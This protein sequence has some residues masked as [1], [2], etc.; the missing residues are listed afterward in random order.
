MKARLI[1]GIFILSVLI[2]VC[3]DSHGC[4]PP[5]TTPPIP[6]P[7][8]W[9]VVP[10]ATS[11]TSIS[12]KA[13][14]ATDASGVEY[15][16][17]CTTSGG[18]DS[19]WQDGTTYTDTGLQPNTQYCYRVRAR[20]KS[21]NHNLTNW[22]TTTPCAT[23][24]EATPPSPDPMTW[25]TVPYATGS[26]SIAMVATTA[27]D[28]SGVEYFFDCTTTGGHDSVWQ[29]NTSYTDTGLS[30]STQYCYKVQA[31]DKS[32]NQNAT[33]WSTTQCA[34]TQTGGDTTPPT[35]NPAT[36]ASVPT[37]VSDTA[38]TMTA[39]TGTDVSGPV[40][41]SFDETSGNPGGT[42][43]G[44][45]TNPVY[46]DS[47]LQPGTQYTYT[48]QMRD[49]LLNTGTASG[50]LSAITHP[51]QASNPTPANGVTDV[52]LTQD[53]SWDPVSGATSYDV[54]FGTVS[55]GTFQGNQ[56]GTTF[57]TGTMSTNTTY[58]WRIDAKNAG[59]TTT[60]DVWSFTTQTPPSPDP[61]T[62]ATEP[63]ATGE[64][65]ISMTA[66]TATDVSGV[67]YYF[68]CAAG[69]CHD[70]GWQD[71][72]TYQDTGLSAGTGYSYQ[73]KARDKSPNQNETNWSLVKSA[74]TFPG[75][76]SNLSPDV[77]A[78]DVSVDVDLRWIPGQGATSHDVYFGTDSSAV[79]NANT[80]S[81]EWKGNQQTNIY[82][83]PTPLA[84][85]TTYFWRIDEKNTS[86]TTTGYV[87]SFTTIVAPPGQAT[88][89]NPTNGS[90]NVDV[91]VE[92]SWTAGSGATSHNI[93][94]GES[95]TLSAGDLKGNQI[96]TTFDP[97]ILA[98]DTPYY[99]RIDEKNAGGTTVGETWSFRTE[100]LDPPTPNPMNWVTEPHPA[101]TTTISMMATTASD[102]RGVEYYFE[103]IAGNGHDSGWVNSATFVDSGLSPGKQYIYR[104]KARD[105]SSNSNET[106]WSVS[107]ATTI[108]GKVRN[109]NK[110]TWHY[111]IQ[112]AID[113]ATS[114]NTLVVLEG[115]YSE[116]IAVS[117]K[118]VILTSTNPEFRNVVNNTI[119]YG[120]GTT[121]VVKFISAGGSK[122][123]G[124]TVKNSGTGASASDSSG[125]YCEGTANLD[126][127]DCNV[128][129]NKYGIWCDATSTTPG[130]K[131][132]IVRINTSTGIEAGTSNPTI[133]N[134]LVHNNGGD[135]ISV[136]G[137]AT[138][139]N[140]TV[141]YNNKGFNCTAAQI[142]NCIDWGNT[143]NSTW[144]SST[145][146]YSCVQDNKSGEGNFN[147]D[148]RFVDSV[149][150]NYHLQATI[151]P[152]VNSGSTSP[153]HRVQADI[154]GQPR[155]IGYKVDIGA[156]EA[157]VSPTVWYVNG[158]VTASGAGTSW[159][160]AFK[161]LQDALDNGSLEAGH[162]I[163][164]AQGTYKPDEATSGHTNNDRN[165][166]FRL[167]VDVA[168]YG[169]FVGGENSLAERDWTYNKTILSGDI[170]DDDIDLPDS[171]NSYHVITSG[172]GAV[173][174][175]FVITKGYANNAGDFG[176]GGMLNDGV[177][178]VLRNCILYANHAADGL[179]GG[180][181]YNRNSSAAIMNCIFNGNKTGVDGGGIYNDSSHITLINCTITDNFAGDDAGGIYNVSSNPTVTNC[182]LWNNEDNGGTGLTAQID[183]GTPV[184]SYSC[185][186]DWVGGTGNIGTP[187]QFVNPG[188]WDA[189]TVPDSIIVQATVRDLKGQDETG[190]HPDFEVNPYAAETGIVGPYGAALDI[191]GKPDYALGSSGS[192][193][194]DPRVDTTHG[195]T[196][197]YDWYH[198][199]TNNMSTPIWLELTHQGNGV[200][201][202]RD[203]RFFPIDGHLFATYHTGDGG[204]HNFH[205]TLELH[206]IFT[207][208]GTSEYFRLY[209]S[210]DDMF[211]YID[212]KLVLDIGGV[213]SP[214][215]RYLRI[216]D[217]DGYGGDVYLYMEVDG[218]GDPIAPHYAYVDLNLQPNETYTF[219]LFYAERHTVQSHLEFSTTI[220]LKINFT[221]GDYHLQAGS[222]CIDAGD[223][224][225]VPVGV[226]TDLE[227]A[228][229]FLDDPD[230]DDTGNEGAQG[231]P[232]VDMGAYEYQAEYEELTV[233]AGE[234]KVVTLPANTEKLDEAEILVNGGVP[235]PHISWEWS[236]KSVPFGCDIDFDHY[237][238]NPQLTLTV[239]P[240]V[241]ELAEYVEYRLELSAYE[242]LYD[243]SRVLLKSDEVKI[244]VKPGSDSQ[245]SPQVRAIA[246][247]AA[248]VG[249][250]NIAEITLPDNTLVI[251]GVIR[252]DGAPSGQLM[253]RWT[254]IV[255]GGSGASGTVNFPPGEQFVDFRQQIG[256]YLDFSGEFYANTTATFSAAGEYVIKL[257]ASDGAPDS[258][259][260]ALID[261]TVNPD[262]SQNLPPEV[263]AGPN[264]K[265]NMS[266]ENY[267]NLT[268][269]SAKDDHGLVEGQVTWST[270]SG[271][272]NATFG[273]A[274]P[275][276]VNT[277]TT[278]T[279][280]KAG[281]YVLKLA[282]N[283]GSNPEVG[284]RMKVEVEQ[285]FD[286]FAGPDRTVTIPTSPS[287]GDLYIR[288]AS[289][290]GGPDDMT[291]MWTWVKLDG[292]PNFEV[293][294]DDTSI[295]KPTVTFYE[296]GTYELTLSAYDN[297]EL[298]GQ[299]NAVITVTTDLQSVEKKL[300]VVTNHN[301]CE[302]S[303]FRTVDDGLMLQGTEDTMYFGSGPIGL[304]V[305]PKYGRVFVGYHGNTVVGII[306]AETMKPEATLNTDFA[307]DGIKWDQINERLYCL[308]KY[309][310]EI[311]VFQ[312]YSENN[313]FIHLGNMMLSDFQG[314]GC[315]IALNR[316]DGLLYVTNGTTM[317][318]SYALNEMANPWPQKSSQNISVSRK[319]VGIDFRSNSGKRYIYTGGGY[320][321]PYHEY[322]VRTEVGGAGSNEIH[323]GQY[324]SV[325]GVSVDNDTGFVYVTTWNETTATAEIR[326]Y[327]GELTKLLYSNSSYTNG[328]ATGIC[329]LNA[330][331]QKSPDFYLAVD[332]QL[333]VC[334]EPPD[335]ITYDI[336]YKAE[337]H[338][339]T[340]VEVI[341]YLPVELDFDSATDGG[342]YDSAS[343]TVTWTLPDF[344][345]SE[346]SH[347]YL[348][349]NVNDRAKP[350]GRILNFCK[351][352]SD[353]Y[354]TPRTEITEVCCWPLNQQIIYV[355]PRAVDGKNNGTS[356]DDAYTHL[357][358]ALRQAKSLG[359]AS[360]NAIWVT[361]GLMVGAFELADGVAVYGGFA[362]FES[363]LNERDLANPE[364]ATALNGGGFYPYVV[365]GA[366][367]AIL[368]GFTVCGGQEAGI[369]G[370]DVSMTIANCLIEYNHEGIHLGCASA[371]SY[372]SP[373]LIENN[374]IRENSSSGIFCST[375]TIKNN[376]IC[377]NH[378]SGV[379]IYSWNAGTS[380]AV[381]RNN[382]I[383]YNDS[384][385]IFKEGYGPSAIISN[386]I[387]WG[388]SGSQLQNC[389]A[390]YS[391]I[392][393]DPGSGT[394]IGGPPSF[395]NVCD[396]IDTVHRGYIGTDG[397][398]GQIDA[399]K[400]W[401]YQINDVIEIEND[402][403]PRN[404]TDVLHDTYWDK[405]TFE[406]SFI[407]YKQDYYDTPIYN[408]GANDNVYEDYHIQ[409]NSPCID[410]GEPGDY[411]GESDIDGDN[412]VIEI[413]GKGDGDRDVDI[414]ADEFT[415]LPSITV[416]AGDYGPIV[417]PQTG[418]YTLTL[419]DAWVTPEWRINTWGWSV[420]PGAG[421]TL[422]LNDWFD[423]STIQFSSPGH[424]Y[425]TLTIN[426]GPS[427]VPSTTEVWV[428]PHADNNPPYVYPGNTQAVVLSGDTATATMRGIVRD[429][430]LPNGTL[431]KQWLPVAGVT[432]TDNSNPGTVATF[433]RDDIYE[434]T[435]R[436]DDSE[437]V[438]SKTVR[439]V[440]LKE[441][442]PPVISA[443]PEGGYTRNVSE[444]LY[445]E[446][447][448]IAADPQ[449]EIK[450][451]YW[452]VTALPPE[453]W[454]ASLLAW[455]PENAKALHP[456]VAFPLHGDYELQLNVEFQ[457]GVVTDTVTD[458]VTVEVIDETITDTTDPALT[459]NTTP[460]P[461]PANYDGSIVINASATDSDSGVDYISLKVDSQVLDSV[462]G[463]PSY[464]TTLPLDYTLPTYSISNGAHTL[465]AKAVDRVGKYNTQQINFSSN[466]PIYNF[467]VTPEIATPGDCTVTISASFRDHGASDTWTLSIPEAS[468]TNSG[469]GPTMS[470]QV[471]VCEWDDGTYTVHLEDKNH[472]SEEITFKVMMNSG[473]GLTAEIKNLEPI[474]GPLGSEK[475]P[476]ITNGF[477][478]LKGIADHE[479]FASDVSYKIEVFD[480]QAEIL[481]KN[482]TPGA[483]ADGFCHGTVGDA[484]TNIEGDFGQLDLSGLPNKT[485]QLLLTV[486]CNGVEAYDSVK[487]ALDCP[488]KIGNVKF[489]QEDL[490]VPIGGIP[491]RVVRTYDSLN[492]LFDSEFGYG[493][494][495]SIAN[496]DIELN[497]MRQPM[498]NWT[499]RVGGN[500]DRDVTLTL[501]NGTRATFVCELQGDGPYNVVYKAPPGVTATLEPE[502]S[503]TLVYGGTCIG[504]YWLFDGIDPSIPTTCEV[505]VD[506]SLHDF[507]GF[508]LTTED[509]TKYHISRKPY[510]TQTIDDPFFDLGELYFY[511]AYGKP[512]LSSIETPNGEKIEFVVAGTEN[513]TVTGVTHYQPAGAGG[514]TPTKAIKIQYYN[515]GINNG[516]IEK[517]YPPSELVDG[518]G[519][520]I[521]GA[522]PSLKYEYLNGN[523][524]EVHKL[525]DRDTEQYEVI[526]YS[527]RDE[528]QGIYER[529]HYVTDIK[530]PRGISPI[531]Y[532]YNDDGQ[533]IGIFDAKNEYITIN[534]ED[535]RFPT[536]NVEV[537]LD[538]LGNETIYF[539]NARGNVVTIQNNLGQQTTYT[540][541]T[542][543]NID[544]PASITTPTPTGSAVTTYQ[545]TNY[546]NGTVE[547]EIITDPVYNVTANVYDT[548][549]NVTETSQWRFTGTNPS[550]F[551]ADYAEVSRTTSVYYYN[552][553]GTLNLLDQGTLTNLLA[554]TASVDPSTGNAIERTDYE[555]D[556][557]MRLW[558]VIKREIPALLSQTDDVSD[559]ITSYWYDAASN[560]PDRPYSVSEPYY[561]SQIGPG[562]PTYVNYS[563]YNANGNQD[564]SWTEWDDPTNG[565]GIDKYVFTV[566]T[567]DSQ[568]R[569]I[570]TSRIVDDDS[571]PF[572]PVGDT[573]LSE[574]V[575]TSTQYNSIG[576]VDLIL[577]EHS[578]LTK[579]GYDE[580]GNIVETLLYRNS[581]DYLA[582]TPDGR[583][584]KYVW[585]GSGYVETIFNS[586]S[587]FVSDSG[588][589]LLTVSQT[590]YDIDGRAVISVGPYD[591]SDTA[592]PPVGTET[593][594]DTLG[595]VIGT[596]RWA[597]VAIQTQNV[598]N[599]QGQVVGKSA[600]GWTTNGAAP[601]AGNELSYTKTIYDVASRVQMSIT[602]NEQG[603]EQP[604]GYKYDK[605]GKQVAVADATDYGLVAGTDYEANGRWYVIKNTVLTSLLAIDIETLA[606]VSKT[607]YKGNQRWKVTDDRNNITEFIYDALGRVIT[608]KY[609]QTVV[610]EGGVTPI[611]TYT[612]VGYDSLGGKEWQSE[613]TD[614]DEIASLTDE[615]GLRWFEYDAAG[616]LTA[617]ILAKV[618]VNPLPLVEDWKRPRCEYVYD[619]FGNLVEQWDKITE[620][621]AEPPAIDPTNK[622]QTAFTYD[623]LN[624]QTSRTLPN[625][626]TE[627]TAYDDFGRV[628][629][630]IDFKE[631]AT[632]YFYNGR[633]QLRYKRYYEADG[634]V[635][636]G[637]TNYPDTWVQQVEYT[638]D[639]L[640]R[641]TQII[642]SGGTTEY[643]YDT[644]G[645]MIVVKSPEGYV[646]YIYSDV[647]GRKTQTRSYAVTANLNSDV[648]AASN[649][650]VT[651]VEYTYE[652]L[653]R[654]YEAKTVKRNSNT[655]S[656]AE[657]TTYNYDY[658]GNRSSTTTAN[659]VNGVTATY[660]NDNCNRLTNLSN[661]HNINGA[662]SSFAYGLYAN[663]MRH[664][665]T[666]EI[667]TS[668][669]PTSETHNITY[670]YDNLNRLTDEDAY[671]TTPGDTYN[672]DYTYDLVG[673]RFSR[674]VIANSQ[675][676]QTNY[677]YD[678]TDASVD[679]LSR[680]EHAGPVACVPIGDERYYA[681]ADGG[682][683]T[684]KTSAGVSIGKLKAFMLGLPNEAARYMLALVLVLVPVSFFA[685]MF[686]RLIRHRGRRVQRAKYLLRQ[687]LIVLLAYLMLIQPGW[688]ESVAEASSQYSQ[689]TTGDWATYKYINYTYD[690][691][692]SCIT[693]TTKNDSSTVV[694]AVQYDYN[695]RNKL[696]KV[697]TDPISGS[698]VSVV[699][700]TYND[701][702]IRVKAYS[703]DRL[704]VGETK[705]N[706]KTT[707]FLVDAYNHTGYAQ[708]LE[709]SDGTTRTTYTVGDDVITQCTGATPKHLIYDGHGSTR[710]LTDVSGALVADQVFNYDGY[711]VRIG[712]TGTSQTNLQYAGEYYDTA[713]K[714]YNL[715]ARYYNPLN[716]RFNQMD[717]FAGSPQDPQSLHKYLYC[718]AN[719]VNGIDPNGQEFSFTG[720]LVSIAIGAVIGAI[721]SFAI[722][723]RSYKAGGINV[724][725]FIIQI[726]LGALIGALT[727]AAGYL[728]SIFIGSW[729]RTLAISH[730]LR[731]ILT[732]ALSAAASAFFGQVIT[733][734]KY[735]MIDK[736]P[737]VFRDSL[738]RAILATCIGFV[739]GGVLVGLSL[740]MG[741]ISD[742]KMAPIL[743][744]P[745]LDPHIEYLPS[746]WLPEPAAVGAL[747]EFKVTTLGII[748]GVA[749]DS[750]ANEIDKHL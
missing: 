260:E 388:N 712:Y 337:G 57:D 414:G 291:L 540:Y 749:S 692:G 283:D 444:V 83:P 318:Y 625:N 298:L 364:Y 59:G 126:I 743:K 433:E 430:G 197:F 127:R 345:G 64:T 405:I 662:L 438:T 91:E 489:S 303:Y 461:I 630:N 566:N 447:A 703:Y 360:V 709:E 670:S 192:N 7:M 408:W 133:L 98:S 747:A 79:S 371:C 617:T 582:I 295:E 623:W 246:E 25:A 313:E 328:T 288:E 536:D 128:E 290:T 336:H 119:I 278:A 311:A 201:E 558:H 65:S 150:Y 640:G 395:A 720:L 600:I 527:Y 210:D 650:D 649:N 293:Y 346:N 6:N 612:H 102:L 480:N 125:I 94:F 693:K 546:A 22:S 683:L 584:A 356:W 248:Q 504:Y 165:E 33:G 309:G 618:D 325:L 479:I 305:D 229:R 220:E 676:L 599:S 135:G 736:K 386:C 543:A 684:Y 508:V 315:D 215:S 89:P 526:K 202:F 695:L 61:M 510:G 365:T 745:V 331:P 475:I 653:G 425:V 567:L 21:P 232:V 319:A 107:A 482:V 578:N 253:A 602:L 636:G 569:A 717:S 271:P 714:Q 154:D 446:D 45:T 731:Y 380:A 589:S 173:V 37:A 132:N 511:E 58:Y 196:Y 373:P 737:F 273:D 211:L 255:L 103:C 174:D 667:K 314:P 12:M 426:P 157:D 463:A 554:W 655:V 38:I 321:N 249:Q 43:S 342:V 379:Y 76:A 152:C 418:T 610:Q 423:E 557:K 383:A 621:L 495:Y 571:N 579:Y 144:G 633:G 551:P 700:Y 680:E 531:R 698:T 116:N 442:S 729:L 200:Y 622:R 719:P 734:L 182:V 146:T 702:G 603:Y 556:T 231:P 652:K 492:R 180:G 171:G 123:K 424:Y 427:E 560:S 696:R 726:G 264:R 552:N 85:N 628:M 5:D 440:V 638:Y 42:D 155:V 666:E 143:S 606:N 619:N 266:E 114:G 237:E 47:G 332:D 241:F 177:S 193:P 149:N 685:P 50:P 502:P 230:T 674:T 748:G 243:G 580:T 506:L 86:G 613:T 297:S 505:D 654:L 497:E 597:N 522:I 95:P 460:D 367:G 375:A 451:I 106:G 525:V 262:P 374:R 343:R 187:P 573:P 112:E 80:S 547:T 156:D 550:A 333:T 501:P 267:V 36:F 585:N 316:E 688:L 338:T 741:W 431:I 507:P 81:P 733:E 664:T 627:Y 415:P 351:I 101:G 93:Y 60:G 523:L 188:H 577:D 26:T 494:S 183:G 15:F 592:H 160:T 71:S 548:L 410:V 614:E 198:N 690:A 499:R 407:S 565:A 138:I 252:D 538:R 725:E 513:P 222:P 340:N 718:H 240:A 70:S 537:V 282:A 587:A 221:P 109:K 310:D 234:D 361:G 691:N 75:K 651:R 168:L 270:Y 699:E 207:Y 413:S 476:K 92:L 387:I 485:Y 711:G 377:N 678:G 35:P 574:V 598:T 359:C 113:G 381:I 268:D 96:S 302:I 515:D 477:Y 205:F 469:S 484:Q 34:T 190:G 322:L 562:I 117:G 239:N 78:T 242:T 206:T 280:P 99:W 32:L 108:I 54:Y 402:G 363:S 705:S 605:A 671:E 104:V 52:A 521:S 464:P 178:P 707:T 10:Y 706:E 29:D 411:P 176:G 134:N 4:V 3:E 195:E 24:F 225:D 406:P 392:E 553:G 88:I 159:G 642:E 77:G 358:D 432:F 631:Q 604:T 722:N 344:T 370:E 750:A 28:A 2:C 244:T 272:A 396:F 213:H 257:K 118:Y 470:V 353:E 616:R 275:P 420:M 409:S 591:P 450:D 376:L 572:G 41:Y 73:A 445:L 607:E 713:L 594:Y 357:D 191:D 63:Y 399:E 299:D 259:G 588:T 17:D 441:G 354:R 682:G 223:N 417:L 164:V 72:V 287:E 542:G 512:Y 474:S 44:W 142:T 120:S 448:W 529:D 265:I 435:L 236:E 129:G 466:S 289:V 491:L 634:T 355:D 170:D 162:E 151:S 130:I 564:Y 169:G 390:T 624:N 490:V 658:A 559:I 46:T 534:H 496:M 609:P 276:P 586:F 194:G 14:T 349:A 292:S 56:I 665:V 39:T 235:G 166:T 403:I 51:G 730:G 251:Q 487:F 212:G 686:K 422:V 449:T 439:I 140:N 727:G 100:D 416:V 148:P 716:G 301:D 286:V 224:D 669:T 541:G 672:V 84:N 611:H 274:T 516:R 238:M 715:R 576:K 524:T 199:T 704:R 115:T 181:M 645:R 245:S 509:G 307:L 694:E 105:G 575:L 673:N 593:V 663:G 647:T 158:A 635:G 214:E 732:G 735:W 549:G 55:P 385:G 394:N 746:G 97:G 738:N 341:D 544:R 483:G 535:V 590:Y 167:A 185:V 400:E 329:V 18:Y 681:Y 397:R 443:G 23:T 458:R 661:T 368:D 121:S 362:G 330:A 723:Y 434:L 742:I 384:T 583:L 679:R 320:Y 455:Y 189:T 233:R 53:L 13:T 145:V 175:G 563:H 324:T 300:Y 11:P 641:R 391:C 539:Y 30:P 184:V 122:F 657:V 27:T 49:S 389:T 648:L 62:W 294:F 258:I 350:A 637:N 179:N 615:D 660:T 141:A 326:V 459:V 369:F 339:A 452:T 393:G 19:V 327:D 530:D 186:T 317:I 471:N 161:Y 721:S 493:W 744:S 456:L 428:W 48:V 404:I 568:G 82:D 412:R 334:V 646:R 629:V 643:Y 312:W 285:W 601:V 468:Y 701:D 226:T 228:P 465:I 668:E 208:Y 277:V 608:T 87:W 421:V 467:T 1:S 473:G 454:D 514:Y 378:S 8:T 16:F 710:Q 486:L 366:E 347:L 269:S 481:I 284:D 596:R 256:G 689:I 472:V 739:T 498:G 517:I 323:L 67:E 687:G 219:D 488:L 519:A 217:R 740:K 9:A 111:T 40:M 528:D 545:Y 656:P 74:I 69:G 124:F 453:V 659:G 227:L 218:N 279:F 437:K 382:T 136:S 20:D 632:G 254:G 308:E 697:T 172:G 620:S 478:L 131:N 503:C 147:S 304:A 520:P 203:P 626:T 595:R 462:T 728:F 216:E 139:T 68:D 561:R 644:E 110:G 66:T 250:E 348:T 306:N 31:R 555:Y 419:N 261:V 724:K 401:Q 209:K 204:N 500:F 90:T 677:Y 436:A 137:S 581:A 675:T 352:E 639:N 335:Q 570:E 708:I 163:W 281:T 457:R 533:L 398:V 518:Y 296:T 372:S 247:I 263:E 532:V 429:D 153:D